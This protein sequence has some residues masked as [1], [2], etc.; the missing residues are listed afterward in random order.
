MV[1][2]NDW[3]GNELKTILGR[4]AKFPAHSL[5]KDTAGIAMQIATDEDL[6]D[7]GSNDIGDNSQSSSSG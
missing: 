2:G 1:M 7:L 3:A 5:T 6:E 4:V